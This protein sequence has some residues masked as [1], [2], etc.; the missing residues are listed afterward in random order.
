MAASQTGGA[1][2]RTG[3]TSSRGAFTSRFES[4]ISGTMV[5]D[6]IIV[7]YDDFQWHVSCFIWPTYCVTECKG[8]KEVRTIIPRQ[9][10][11]SV[12]HAVHSRQYET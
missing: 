2:P 8:R 4:A 7:S 3:R 11:K 12:E 9:N 10:G 6:L 5:I 1:T